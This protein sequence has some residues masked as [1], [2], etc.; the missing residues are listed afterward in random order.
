MDIL[1]C[2]MSLTK[3]HGN[4]ATDILFN[5]QIFHPIHFVYFLIKAIGKERKEGHNVL[6]MYDINDFTWNHLVE[7]H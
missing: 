5:L 4:V 2:K 6:M 7:D 1:I 3:L